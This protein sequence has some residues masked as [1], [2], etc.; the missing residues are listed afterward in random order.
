MI[1]LPLKFVQIAL[2]ERIGI[3]IAGDTRLP[4]FRRVYRVIRTF[5]KVICHAVYQAV[6]GIRIAEIL[7]SGK[8]PCLMLL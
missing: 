2:G 8:V 5:G 4:K 6:I 1:Q 3:D 7:Q